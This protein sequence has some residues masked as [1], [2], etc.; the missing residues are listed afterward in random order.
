M[1]GLCVYIPLCITCFHF[2]AVVY[3]I[4]SLVFGFPQGIHYSLLLC[5][6]E[7]S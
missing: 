6:V 5:S 2:Y 4:D 1:G 7:F 3:S